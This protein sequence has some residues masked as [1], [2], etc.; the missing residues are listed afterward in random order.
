MG[1]HRRRRYRRLIYDHS[2]DATRPTAKYA[3][4]LTDPPPTPNA[5]PEL[6][7]D[8]VYLGAVPD[9][10]FAG[11]TLAGYGQISGTSVD[12]WQFRVTT[13]CNVTLDVTT[14]ANVPDTFLRL[15]NASGGEIASNDDQGGGNTDS[16]LQLDLAAG[17]Y[18]VGISGYPNRQYDVQGTGDRVNS[19]TSGDYQLDIS[20]SIQVAPQWKP[21]IQASGNHDGDPSPT[22]FGKYLIGGAV[23]DLVVT[24]SASV[25]P[26]QGFSTQSVTFDSDF[27]GI[28]DAND[29]TDNTPIDGWTWKCNVSRLSGD[30]TLKI[31]ASDTKGDWSAPAAFSI[32]TLQQPAWMNPDLTSITFDGYLGCYDIS[33]L[34]GQRIGTYTPTSWPSFLAYRDG[35]R[36]YNGMYF[37][38]GVD[39]TYT[40][41]GTVLDADVAPAFGASVLGVG[42]QFRLALPSDRGS[43]SINPYK[44]WKLYDDPKG[45]EKE[46][47]KPPDNNDVGK[48][49]INPPD[50]TF[51]WEQHYHLN[52]NL[53]FD[54][55]D[56]KFTLEVDATNLFEVKLPTF[57]VPTPIPGL[58]VAVK[59]HFGFGPYFDLN[60]TVGLATGQPTFQSA[61]VEIGIGMSIGASIELDVGYGLASAGVDTTAGG[62]IGFAVS[63]DTSNGWTYSIPAQL[64][65]DIDLVGSLAWGAWSGKLNLCHFEVD[66]DLWSSGAAG[67]LLGDTSA[68]DEPA[69]Q[70][71]ILST[72][73]A[74]SSTGEMATAWVELDAQGNAYPLVVRRRSADGEWSD[75]EVVAQGNNLRGE[76]ALAYLADGRLM[77]IWSESTLDSGLVAGMDPHLVA[78]AQEI[79]WSIGDPA[80][81]WS[82]PMALTNN[83]TLDDQPSVAALPDGSAVVVWRALSGQDYTQGGVSN[84]DYA[85]FNGAA[86]SAPAALIDDMRQHAHPVV[87]A[88]PNGQVVAIWLAASGLDFSN[89]AVL[90]ATYFMGMWLGKTAINDT[91]NTFPESLRLA[92]LPSGDVLAFWTEE[93]DDGTTLRMSTRAVDGTWSATTEALAPQ[94]AIGNP[95]V[96][97]W[98]TRV[99]IVWHGIGCDSNI[100][101]VSR[102]FGNDCGWSEPH[103]LTSDAG[104][105]WWPMAGYD[106]DGNLDVAYILDPL[107]AGAE[108]MADS[109][110]SPIVPAAPNLPANLQTASIAC[111]SD[112]A[113]TT[114][115]LA[116]A[117][118][119]A[120]PDFANDILITIRNSGLASSDPVTAGL[121]AGDPAQGELIDS[122]DIPGLGIGQS[123]SVEVPWWPTQPTQTLYAVVDTDNVLT[124]I[125]R[126]NNTASAEFACVPVPTLT[127]APGSDTGTVGDGWTIVTQPTVAGM[128][129]PQPIMAETTSP[130]DYI[131]IYLDDTDVPVLQTTAVDAGY[132][133]LLPLL[134]LGGHTVWARAYDSAGNPSAMSAPL[135]LLI[136][137]F[138]I[139]TPSPLSLLPGSDT[140]VPGNRV[141]YALQPQLG[142]TA[143]AGC[144]IMAFDRSQPGA[145]TASVGANGSFIVQPSA[146]MSAGSHYIS[147][148]QSDG[149]GN[150]SPMTA[151][152]GL[153][154]IDPAQRQLVL[155]GSPVSDSFALRGASGYVAMYE[156]TAPSGLPDF[157]V[158]TDEF[159]SLAVH[160]G[161]GQDMLQIDGG[162]FIMNTDAGSGTQSLAIELTD[163]AEMSFGQTQHLTHLGIGDGCTAVL[164]L[165]GQ[166]V[167]AL[168]DLAVAPAGK[169]DLTNN[170]MILT[171]APGQT[172]PLAPINSSIALAQHGSIVE[173]SRHHQLRS[174]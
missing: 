6:F 103:R 61:S 151:P 146:A 68:A 2:D 17:L 174:A 157:M 166:H 67:A 165:N 124:E 145:G 51:S 82:P 66:T 162:S 46:E 105:A 30:Q 9:P 7:P 140:G 170:C 75:P 37:G 112:L 79:Y 100:Y 156:N 31:W 113:V 84:I 96:S 74:Q 3:P 126:D 20:G 83:N 23:P 86:W 33:S 123:I 13:A 149:A 62:K 147:A 167:L 71:T 139:P 99:D 18:C 143:K 88:L 47:S 87:T 97:V 70:P 5:K 148:C 134:S 137:P 52:D 169:L 49:E 57:Y 58:N 55:L 14:A 160:G 8:A 41:A 36:T 94:K 115:D 95:N 65:I 53:S 11:Y 76:P 10:T 25:T 161:A 164:A 127:L 63:Y 59:P 117:N 159:D 136:D 64:S 141:T 39:A 173:R 54:S 91:N 118:F 48:T 108:L 27:N 56:E 121:Y 131:A 32:K 80:G 163:G 154:L 144:T 133:A 130:Q 1:R 81:N 171:P 122:A 50:V 101:V 44:F 92:A 21:T 69:F 60:Y 43:V 138:S 142:G 102:D 111:L 24:F 12:F 107:P 98:G 125:S 150:T 42:S 109:G 29:Y 78:S 16:Y 152:L 135:S 73:T 90:Q 116:L 172:D 132:Q 15:F 89:A 93:T 85:T 26:N 77:A 119:P 158:P 40:L 110:G 34:I 129:S 38:L 35:Q 4:C 72:A 106:Q 19:A 114:D 153:L 120:V 45:F 104:I 128:I 168:S 22:V 28:R 155:T